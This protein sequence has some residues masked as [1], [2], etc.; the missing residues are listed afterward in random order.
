[1]KSTQFVRNSHQPK[2]EKATL[3]HKPNAPLKAET[4]NPEPHLHGAEHELGTELQ[5]DIT[6][7]FGHPG[8]SCSD[9]P[10]HVHPLPKFDS[11]HS[12]HKSEKDPETP[13]ASP[14]AQSEEAN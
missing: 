4:H 14:R 2:M 1:V 11:K 5:P 13:H 10:P 7:Q 12:H 3:P 9:L 8:V 6:E